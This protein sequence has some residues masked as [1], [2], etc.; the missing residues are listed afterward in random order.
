MPITSVVSANETPTRFWSLSRIYMA[1]AGVAYWWCVISGWYSSHPTDQHW[2]N[3]DADV[4]TC[5]MIGSIAL[6]VEWCSL[7]IPS[8]AIGTH[9][10]AG[11]DE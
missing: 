8:K 11:K 2:W 9:A 1:A 6:V 3:F 10:A 5:V 7:R 4:H